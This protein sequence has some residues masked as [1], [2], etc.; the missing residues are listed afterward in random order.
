[1]AHG[2]DPWSPAFVAHPYDVYATLREQ[3]PVAWF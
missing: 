3:E 1:M 2:F